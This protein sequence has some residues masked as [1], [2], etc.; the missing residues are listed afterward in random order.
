MRSFEAQY[1]EALYW[2]LEE[3]NLSTNRTSED[4]YYSFG[5]NIRIDMNKG[6]PVVTSKKIFFDKA[7]HEFLWILDG[8]TNIEYLNKHGIHWWDEYADEH[9]E[10]GPTYG[11][12]L[13]NHNGVDQVQYVIQEIKDQSRRAV[14]TLWN[15][16]ELDK[17]ALP[18]CFT[19][20]VFSR[21]GLFLNM[22]MSLRSSDMFLGLP[23]DIIMGGLF[24]NFISEKTGLLPGF[25]NVNMVDAHIYE[26]HKPAVEEYLSRTCLKLPKLKG[27][28]PY[29]SLKDY[30]C[31]GIIKAEMF[32]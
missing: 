1:K 30:D 6:F 25:L 22:N 16:A 28:F 20:F 27:T 11:H 31:H 23:Y 21:N 32:N 15:P 9:G 3:N 17:M 12:Q 2:C 10:L 19:E 5:Q 29:Y 18:P 26:S 24:L 7:L 4:T 8:D 13:R 14:I